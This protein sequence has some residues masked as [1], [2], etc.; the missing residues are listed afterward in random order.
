MAYV[1]MAFLKVYSGDW[2]TT[3]VPLATLTGPAEVPEC[4]ITSPSAITT[5]TITI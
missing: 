2:I 4:T 1:V 5:L 3:A